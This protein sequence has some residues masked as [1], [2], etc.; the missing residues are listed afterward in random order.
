MDEIYITI[1]EYLSMTNIP[2]NLVVKF[3]QEPAA[4]NMVRL[5]FHKQAEFWV[6][7][8]VDAEKALRQRLG[9]PEPFDWNAHWQNERKRPLGRS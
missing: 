4:E 8:K 3:E 9:I 1:T 7:S 5:G 2:K 6:I